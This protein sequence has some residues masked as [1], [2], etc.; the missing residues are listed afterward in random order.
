MARINLNL[1]DPR[2]RDA[3]PIN[4]VIRWN[5][6][7]LVYPSGER[8]APRHWSTAT[9]RAKASLNTAPEF[10]RNLSNIVGKVE[11]TYLRF[12]N[13]N[14]HRAP[15]VGELRDQLDLALGRKVDDGP[16]TLF[17]FIGDYIAKARERVNPDTGAR[18]AGTTLKKYITTLHHLEGFAK[19]KRR[20]VDFDTVDLACYDAFNAYLTND[21]GLALNSVGKYI[22]TLKT[23][24][25]A[26]AEQG[27]DVNP[28]FR[29]RKF[30]TPSELT[31]KVY[32]NE[33][34]L[35]DLF[36]LD[37][38][39]HPRLERARDLFLVG[40]WTG[41]RFGDFT[42]IRPEQIT[43]DRIRVRTA[44]TGAAVVIPLH[45]C[46]RAVLTKY[47][48]AL[49][50]A[51]SNQKMNAYLREFTAM[52]P[53]L[54]DRVSV[55]STVA[56]VRR[57]VTKAKAELVTTHTARRSFATNLYRAGVPTRTIMAIT[58][59]QTEQAFRLYIRLNADEHA[60]ILQAYMDKAAPLAVVA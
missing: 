10:N 37:L 20:R 21:Q 60:D 26:A 19:A 6:L 48:N 28:A 31:D 43:G 45:P 51:I 24:L 23:F 15:S 13:D 4:I 44:K 33:Q 27:I 5:G 35:N 3:S 25:R 38:S 53:S 29:S 9:Q 12:R 2:S 14:D 41:L 59:H 22:Q 46:V 52:V 49:P 56:G 54:Q 7:R 50:R 1:R 11:G 57:Y 36:H 40:A 30:R 17:A 34:E 58:G 8:I 55:S 42:T 47:G 18:L 32:L 39:A 16:R